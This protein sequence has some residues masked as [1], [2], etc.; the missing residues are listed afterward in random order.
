M[1]ATSVY[2]VNQGSGQV[3]KVAIGGGSPTVLAT[4]LSYPEAIGQDASA[5]YYADEH[6]IYKLAK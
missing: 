2:W 4:G 1:D 3:M 6:G 5:I